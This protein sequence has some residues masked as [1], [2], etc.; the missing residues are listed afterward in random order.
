MSHSGKIEVLPIPV[1]KSS[2]DGSSP[3]TSRPSNR[4]C[5]PYGW[6]PVSSAKTASTLMKL[7]TSKLTM[8][9]STSV[10][11]RGEQ[12]LKDRAQCPPPR[13][14]SSHLR[15]RLRPPRSTPRSCLPAWSMSG[16]TAHDLPILNG[17]RA[18]GPRRPTPPRAPAS[19]L[20]P[21]PVAHRCCRPMFST[22]TRP[23]LDPSFC[24]QRVS[25]S[26]P[27]LTSWSWRT[28]SSHRS[29]SRRENARMPPWAP[30]IPSAFRCAR[31]P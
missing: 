23:R 7:P 22:A 29:T 20:V 16:S 1:G 3:R 14:T 21:M 26:S 9:G 31:K 4:C 27:G 30:M 18:T 10:R 5:Q 19:T 17:L 28:A 12:G 6:W 15:S 13:P 8:I 24:R 25:A 11:K 2:A